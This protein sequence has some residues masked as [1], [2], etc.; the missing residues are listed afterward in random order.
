[1]TNLTRRE[2][3]NISA[4]G[5]GAASFLPHLLQA[6]T[7]H[8]FPIGFQSWVIRDVLVKDFPGTLKMM[9]GLGYQHIE[10][11]S[12][13]GYAKYGFGPLQ[14]MKASEMKNIIKDA[15]LNCV[16][17]HYGFKEL[18]DNGQERMDFA[19]ELGLTQMVV[20]AF[21]LPKNGT[22]SDWKKAA[23]ET[24][25]LG[26]LA[27]KNG[28]QLCYHNHNFEFE[29]LDGELIYD[30]LLQQ[31]DPDLIK[32]QFQV[33]VIIAG[34]KAVDY[35]RKYPGRFISAHLSDWSGAGEVQVPLGTGKVDWK[36]FF[37]ASKTGGL[38]NIFVEMDMPTL[39]ESAAY[40]KSIR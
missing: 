18:K 27:R 17:C 29:K 32:M 19:N 15:G 13:L 1:M 8:N 16:S 35:F 30:A 24:N 20:A 40:L 6:N 5:F 12:P 11:C 33:W 9:A 26:I 36:D 22:L 2:F 34:Y 39:K 7:P 4:T 23:D 14:N 28:I 10:M 37:E 21:G 3:M 25:E 31:L 38:K